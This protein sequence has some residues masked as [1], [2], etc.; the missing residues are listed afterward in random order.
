[1]KSK[2]NTITDPFSGNASYLSDLI[3]NVPKGMVLYQDFFK[4]MHLPEMPVS[5]QGILPILKA[6]SDS[7]VSFS[8]ILGLPKIL[9]ERNLWDPLMQYVLVTQNYFLRSQL[10]TLESLSKQAI[11]Q[12]G[13]SIVHNETM[14]LG[15]LSFKEEAA[16]K[17]RVFAMVDCL[18]Q[19]ALYGLHQWLFE[20]LRVLPNDGTFDQEASFARAQEKAKIAGCS[21]GY[22]LSSATDRLPMSL[23]QA[24]LKWFFGEEQS[25]LWAELLI[26]RDYLVPPSPK[27][28]AYNIAPGNY[29]YSVG[30]PMGAYSS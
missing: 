8:K 6:S 30:Q 11:D 17:L 20:L 23:Q 22:D 1:M 5:S 21:Y 14:P 13:W 25:K 7:K 15:K 26:G 3:E 12:F 28:K 24:I 10:L 9:K 29:R 16:G 27:L 2:L 19:S 4:K 18:T